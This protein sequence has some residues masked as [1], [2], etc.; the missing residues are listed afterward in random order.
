MF[1]KRECELSDLINFFGMVGSGY[2]LC[3]MGELS[4]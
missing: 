2:G 3:V 1:R 4:G